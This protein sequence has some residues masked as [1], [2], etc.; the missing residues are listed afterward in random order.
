VYVCRDIAHCLVHVVHVP[1][2][3]N[4]L[5]FIHC[6][7]ATHVGEHALCDIQ[8]GKIPAQEKLLFGYRLINDLP[9]PPQRMAIPQIHGIKP[10]L[11]ALQHQGEQQACLWLKPAVHTVCVQN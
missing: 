5:F 9:C 2:E 6:T 8:V 4:R 10:D 1:C 3:Q 11:V 7:I